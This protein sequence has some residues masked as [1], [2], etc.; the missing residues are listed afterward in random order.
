M[1]IEKWSVWASDLGIKFPT[2]FISV[3]RGIVILQK[4]LADAGS[5]MTLKDLGLKIAPRYPLQAFSQLMKGGLTM[6]DL[7]KLGWITMTYKA[8][9]V[10]VPV[11]KQEPKLP[12]APASIRCE[13]IYSAY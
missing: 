1:G 3:N 9:P 6:T 7:V 13:R 5:T 10:P 11:I 12:L 4:S 2:Y 8:P